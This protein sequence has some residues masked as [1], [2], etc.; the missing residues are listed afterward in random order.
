MWFDNMYLSQ[1][2]SWYMSPSFHSVLQSTHHQ[3]PSSINLVIQVKLYSIHIWATSWENLFM[4][5]ANNKNADQ[6]AHR[7]SQ[8]AHP[9]SLI[10]PFVV[11]CL[12]SIILLVSISEIGSLYLASVAVQAGLSLPWSQTLKT[13]FLMRRLIWY[14][15]SDTSIMKIFMTLTFGIELWPDRCDIALCRTF[16]AGPTRSAGCALRL[17]LRR[18]QGRSLVRPHIFHT[19]LAL[20]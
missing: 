14:V 13:G 10:S 11:H 20:K 12:D 1:L 15:R 16:K 17:V 6:P 4:P 2:F 9:R 8:L 3:G 7:R 18:S 19:D 5:Y